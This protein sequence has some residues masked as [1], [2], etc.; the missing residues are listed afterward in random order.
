M[1]VYKFGGASVKNADAIKNLFSIVQKEKSELIIVVSAMDK[2][3]NNL[4]LVWEYQLNGSKDKAL[5]KIA[6]IN[7]FHT[8]VVNDLSIENDDNLI[9][10]INSFT[11]KLKDYINSSVNDN[12]AFS[13][14]QIVSYGELLSTTIISYYLNHKKLENTWVDARELIK[15]TNHHQEAR[16]NWEKSKKQINKHINSNSKT[17]VTQGFIGATDDGVTTTLGREGSDYSAAILAWSKEAEEVIIWKDVS[18][19]LNADPKLFKETEQLFKISFKEAIELSY[20]GASVIHPK[21]IKPLQNKGIPL[22]IRS[23]LN[24]SQK[25]SVISNNGENDRDIPSFIFKPNQLLLSITTKDFSFIFEDHIS[26]LFQLFASYGLKVHL[27][28]NSALSFSVCGI[29]KAAMLNQLIEKLSEN[30]IVRYNERVDLLSIRHY[31]NFDLPKIVKN[32][33]VLI[34][35]RSRSTIRYVFKKY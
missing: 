4:E 29:I 19:L 14:D 20:L 15:T 26:D 12:K 9:Q 33:E 10:Q 7:T 3:T 2:T 11:A 13:Y 8:S 30:Y 24:D 32:Q 6:E 28:Q 16:V 34:Q 23:F 22:S 5:E 17:Y 27:M 18:G 31:K 25:G 21:T 1:K 35:Q